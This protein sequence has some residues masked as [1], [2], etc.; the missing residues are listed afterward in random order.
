ML[1]RTFA[2]NGASNGSTL[3]RFGFP[4]GSLQKS[5]QD[6]FARAGAVMH[7]DA[8]D[9]LCHVDVPVVAR[10]YDPRALNHHPLRLCSGFKVNISERGYFP[11]IDDSELSLVLFRSQEIGCVQGW[12]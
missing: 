5:T 6:L 1:N 7:A 4:K 2:A 11:S 9:R 10:C 12:C 8:H 3:V